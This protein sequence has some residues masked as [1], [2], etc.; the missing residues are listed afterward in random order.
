MKS[1]GTK[2]SRSDQEEGNYW[3]CLDFILSIYDT[4]M[5]KY[6]YIIPRDQVSHINKDDL[7][8]YNFLLQKYSFITCLTKHIHLKNIVSLALDNSIVSALHLLYN[9]LLY[10]LLYVVPSCSEP[11]TIP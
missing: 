5:Q 1:E 6:I 9:V 8:N 3:I 11:E 10:F 2:E 7:E 4:F